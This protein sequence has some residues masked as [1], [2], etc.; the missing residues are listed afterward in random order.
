[1]TWPPLSC[2][3]SIVLRKRPPPEKEVGEVTVNSS[4]IALTGTHVRCGLTNGLLKDN[5]RNV[6]QMILV[7]PLRLRK[8]IPHATVRDSE[9]S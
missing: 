4:N 6:S 5:V 1:M 7:H 3:Q 8:L 9:A 2:T